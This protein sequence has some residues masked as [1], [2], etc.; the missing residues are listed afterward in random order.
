MKR[1]QGSN[2]FTV[3]SLC[4][5]KPE[6]RTEIKDKIERLLEQLKD[7]ET[8]IVDNNGDLVKIITA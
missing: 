4:N 1:V 2:L 8:A 6:L 7:G 5:N 3:K